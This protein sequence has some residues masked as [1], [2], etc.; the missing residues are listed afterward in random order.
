MNKKVGVFF[1]NIIAAVGVLL[2]GTA[3]ALLAGSPA[4]ANSSNDQPAEVRPYIFCENPETGAPCGP[5]GYSLHAQLRM[6]EK[7]ISETEVENTMWDYSGVAYKQSNGKWRYPGD[8]IVVIANDKG[9][10]VTVWRT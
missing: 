1:V 2:T 4:Y 10:V 5:E 6:T 3:G 7:D 8:D 9:W